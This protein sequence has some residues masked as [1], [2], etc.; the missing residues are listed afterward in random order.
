MMFLFF[1]IHGVLLINYFN[2]SALHLAANRGHIEIT[3]L[4]IRQENIDYLSCTV[5]SLF[6]FH[7]VSIYFLKCNFFLFE[8]MEFKII[9]V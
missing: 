6:F 5:F 3:D 9:F 1:E 7:Y 2:F 8:F 4:L